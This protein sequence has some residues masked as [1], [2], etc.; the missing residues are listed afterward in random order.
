MRTTSRLLS[1]VFA[2]ALAACEG[3]EGP[4]GPQGLPGQ[5]GSPGQDGQ[6]GLPGADR[7]PRQDGLPG[8]PGISTGELTGVV[9]ELSGGTVVAGAQLAFDP[10]AVAAVTTALDGS[11]TVTL[12]IGVYQVTATHGDWPAATG[13]VSIVAAGNEILDLELRSWKA[14]SDTCLLCHAAADPGIVEDYKTGRMAPFV[15][16]QDC[17][18]TNVV[19]APGHNPMPTAQ[20]CAGCHP[21]QYRGH[22]ANRHSIGYQRTFEA[23]R[24]DDLPP[25]A[26]DQN[27]DSGGTATCQNCHKVE[28]KCDSC[29][30]RHLFGPEQA[31]SPL[32]CATCH[33]GPDHSQWEIYQT[34][35][36]GVVYAAEG[37]GSAPTCA[38]CHMPR[39]RLDANNNPYTDHDLSFGI[40]YGPVGGQPSHRSLRCG[41]Q[42]SYVVSGGVL[43]D[44]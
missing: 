19:G 38:T 20:T 23:G 14:E 28:Q 8:D 43:S 13:T 22:Q 37:E 4:I 3:A 17:H 24:L 5:D 2:A 40:A 7:Q 16:C 27:P 33:M 12:P 34:S 15:S 11:Y 35:K 9:T 36:H 41:G 39:K 1:L 31:R 6:D 44:N 30:T 10:P 18:G 29:H 25:C 32:A 42:L 21:N 26:T